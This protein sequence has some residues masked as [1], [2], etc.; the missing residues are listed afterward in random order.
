M[1]VV[2]ITESSIKQFER[3]GAIKLSGL[4]EQKWLDDLAI[5]V[6]KN[7]ASPG[8][9][10]T[11][12]TPDGEPGNFYDD[13]CNWRRIDEYHDFIMNSPAAAVA[14][15]LMR[16]SECRIY[17]EHVLV[18]EPGTREKTPWHHDLP[19]YGVD[20]SQLCSIWL[21]LDPV[22]K[23]AC[24]EFVAGS[25]RW[26]KTFV[27]RL[28]VSHQNYAD[29]QDQY[30][31]IPDIEAAREQ[32]GILSWEL[33]PGDCIAFHMLTVHGAPGTEALK[34]RRRGFSTRWMGDD[35]VFAKRPWDTSPPFP[36]VELEPGDRMHHSTFPIAWS[37]FA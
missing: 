30:G 16:S 14:G 24:P 21:P 33:S 17:H 25:H 9:W 6:E 32:Y 26:G 15:Q 19:Y 28:F 8:P 23:D 5:G 37:A 31:Q 20:G 7:F 10:A 29:V 36:E 34:T 4:F 1:T 18:K 12:Y 13:Y 11:K 27:P 3:D 22:P 2:P 35:A